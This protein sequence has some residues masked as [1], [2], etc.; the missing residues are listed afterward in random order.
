VQV[1]N[2]RFVAWPGQALQTIAKTW[3]GTNQLNPNV[4]DSSLVNAYQANASD[5][6]RLY[7][8]Q[9]AT[10]NVAGGL[11]PCSNTRPEILGLVCP[12]SSTTLP[13]PPAPA[14]PANV[15]MTP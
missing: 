10:Q 2:V 6:F 8:P 5:N 15:H 13:P 1:N 9:Q 4:S 7:Y 14:A 12:T 11:A 3:S